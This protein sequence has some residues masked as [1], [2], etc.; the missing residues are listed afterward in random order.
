MS[1]P[2]ILLQT[3]SGRSYYN[4][5]VGDNPNH[6]DRLAK[7]IYID[8]E[9]EMVHVQWFDHS[10]KTIMEQLGQ[11]QELFL[12]MHCDTVAVKT[13]I[14]KVEAHYIAPG[15]SLAEVKPHDFFYRY[16]NAIRCLLHGYCSYP[17]FSRY[18]WDDLLATFKSVNVEKMISAQAEHPPDCCHICDML[19]QFD[20][21]SHAHPLR[22]GVAW[23]QH[24][25]HIDDFVLIKADEGPCHIGHICDIQL[26]PGSV[27]DDDNRIV[28]S[29]LG[30]VDR[31][32]CRPEGLLKDE[33]RRLYFRLT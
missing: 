33:V 17:F 3:I 25:Y 14:G 2:R 16:D 23:H 1:H 30:R 24:K 29:V 18:E 27:D 8:G 7:I 21:D 4:L 32:G 28:V 26:P 5:C 19:D 20:Y 10:S 22:R 12:T 31:L 15:Q 11:P 9:D 13:I 6:C